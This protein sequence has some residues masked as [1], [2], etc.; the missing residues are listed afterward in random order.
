MVVQSD[1]YFV[2][3]LFGLNVYNGSGVFD[4]GMK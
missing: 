1:F 4:I 2:C 3:K